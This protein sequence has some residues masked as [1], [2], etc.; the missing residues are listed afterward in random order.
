MHATRSGGVGLMHATRSGGV[1]WMHATRSGGVGWMHATGSGVVG[2]MHA[3]RSGG[4]GW[5][6]ATGS[7]VVGWMH[8]TRSGGV[9]WMHATGSGVV[10]WMHATRSGGV[11][12]MHATGSGVVGWM[13][14]TRSGGVGWMHATRSSIIYMKYSNREKRMIKDSWEVIKLRGSSNDHEC[15]LFFWLLE[16]IPHLKTR[17][18]AKFPKSLPFHR[19]LVDEYLRT[20]SEAVLLTLECF[21]YLLDDPPK[22]EAK[23]RNV[24]TSHVHLRPSVGNEF[25]KHFESNFDQFVSNCLYIDD[26]DEDDDRV[27]VWVKLIRVFCQVVRDE[28]RI[29]RSEKYF[30]C[31]RV[32]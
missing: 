14:A 30:L 6:H 15:N 3:T 27:I 31:C 9:G 21:V 4:V 23:M 17:L 18:A 29:M 2:W 11:G 28:E 1:G 8:A 25:F 13:H 26:V 19:F 22:L 24:A 5:M 20:H 16:H 7:G 32:Q 10:G 12:W